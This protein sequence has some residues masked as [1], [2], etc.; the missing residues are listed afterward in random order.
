VKLKSLSDVLRVKSVFLEAKLT[1]KQV[2]EV[3]DQTSQLQK[4]VMSEFTKMHQ[5]LI[6]LEKR[7]IVELKE[8]VEKIAE[9]LAKNLLDIQQNLTTIQEKLLRSQT[10]LDQEDTIAFLKVSVSTSGSAKALRFSK[11]LEQ[12]MA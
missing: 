5:I 7:L 10:Q 8:N 6:R 11:Q 1:Q 9:K 3:G 2:P 4:F 12:N